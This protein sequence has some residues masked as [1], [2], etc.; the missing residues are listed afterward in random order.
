MSEPYVLHDDQNGNI[1]VFV[2]LIH[3]FDFATSK[4]LLIHGRVFK[5][6]VSKWL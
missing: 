4:C 5:S 6:S 1:I 3:R 2:K